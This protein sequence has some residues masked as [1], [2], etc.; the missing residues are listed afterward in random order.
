MISLWEIE[1]LKYNLEHSAQ[2]EPRYQPLAQPYIPASI[3]YNQVYFL[4]TSGKDSYKF[5]SL[6]ILPLA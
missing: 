1:T 3:D 6:I 4:F 5:S 2:R